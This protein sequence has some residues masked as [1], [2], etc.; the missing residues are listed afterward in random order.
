M[1]KKKENNKIPIDI[2]LNK[3]EWKILDKM[4][5]EYK[6]PLDDMVNLLLT[7]KREE[8]LEKQSE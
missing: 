3:Q 6:M 4:A 2:E 7:K 5:I 8:E 1:S